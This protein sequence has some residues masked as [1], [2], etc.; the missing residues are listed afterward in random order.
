MVLKV[1]PSVLSADFSRLGD[2]VVAVDR[3]GADWI[4]LDVMDGQFVPNLTFGAPIVQALRKHSNKPFDVHL[5]IVEPE[6]YL[7][8]FR[9]AGGDRLTVHAEATKH[10]HRTLQKIRELGAAASVALN[11]ATP[12]S[13]IEHVLGDLDQITIMTVNPGFGGQQ[14]IEAMVPKIRQ[15]RE[16]LQQNGAGRPIEILVDGG[17]N[18]QL[19]RVAEKAG[20]SAVVAGHAIYRA[21]RPYAEVI[22][23]IRGTQRKLDASA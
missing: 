20:A 22:S 4:H 1:A 17:I 11:P 12:L 15:A 19:A 2:E 21:G 16:L 14:F 6:R 10:L 9:A 3:A 5:M 18:P 8:E 7:A 13:A 23:A